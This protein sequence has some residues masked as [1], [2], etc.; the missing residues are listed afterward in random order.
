[1][2]WNQTLSAR[3][4]NKQV[5]AV[6]D[7]SG[8]AFPHTGLGYVAQ[9]VAQRLS[10]ACSQSESSAPA[11]DRGPGGF[12]TG[13]AVDITGDSD[14]RVPEQ[15]SH[16]LD[17]HTR[18]QPSHGRRV[19]E[20]VHTGASTPAAF[21]AT[22]IT[23]NRLRGSTGPPNSVV[24]T[25]PLSCHWLPAR[26]FSADWPALC[27]RSIATTAGERDRAT[28][29][30]R[31]R[32][33]GLESAVDAAEGLADLQP[34]LVQVHDAGVP[35]ERQRLAAP[36]ARCRYQSQSGVVARRL[37]RFQNCRNASCLSTLGRVT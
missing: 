4:K 35:N 11:V 25:R 9:Q 3:P 2:S 34:T 30:L 1:M 36:K 28:G 37:S 13:M 23:R 33:A 5:K 6:S 27:L 16:S 17:M 29:S 32:L 24:K 21:A 20:R 26:S 14:R 31:L 19:T 22:S 15:I 7:T 10:N 12:V 8:T 18:L